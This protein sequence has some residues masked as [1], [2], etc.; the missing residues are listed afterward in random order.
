MKAHTGKGAKEDST[1]CKERLGTR[2]IAVA[3]SRGPQW[4]S[5]VVKV[6]LTQ[7]VQRMVPGE[8]DGSPPRS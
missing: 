5:L 1:Q 6:I 3:R 7:G 4:Y 8:K 2:S